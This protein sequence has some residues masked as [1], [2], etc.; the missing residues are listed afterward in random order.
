MA[1]FV[2]AAGGERVD[3][4]AGAIRSTGIGQDD[5]KLLVQGLNEIVKVCQDVGVACC[6]HPHLGTIKETPKQITRVLEASKIDFCPDCAH[7]AAAGVDV[8]NIV[9]TFA[10]KITYVHLKDWDGT[11]FVELGKGKVDLVGFMQALRSID[12]D[13]W[14]TVEFDPPCQNPNKSAQTNMRY[15]VD[16]FT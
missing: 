13:D 6:Y 16:N 1:Q 2:L 12:Y 14:C 5:W 15:L 10:S 11:E 8:V 3:I 4:G 7:L 9:K